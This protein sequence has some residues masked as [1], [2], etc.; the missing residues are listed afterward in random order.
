ML[1]TLPRHHSWMW[2]FLV[3]HP[4]WIRWR[5]SQVWGGQA[6]GWHGASCIRQILASYPT[7]QSPGAIECKT[8]MMVPFGSFSW[9]TDVLMVHEPLES[10][11]SR[12]LWHPNIRAQR[13]SFHHFRGRHSLA[14]WLTDS[15]DSSK[16][17]FAMWDPRPVRLMTTHVL[18]KSNKLGS[19]GRK[20]GT[21]EKQALWNLAG[22]PGSLVP[23]RHF[24]SALRCSLS[25][26]EGEKWPAAGTRNSSGVLVPFRS[27]EG[28][29]LVS[30]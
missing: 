20:T 12:R 30:L 2:V 23:E 13:L 28:S 6:L 19:E 21:E 17:P 27:T 14:L 11:P 29:H 25:E 9:D 24:L 16:V 26:G 22:S 18:G 3:I 5:G 1:S 10:S 4:P 15:S 8:V 7:I